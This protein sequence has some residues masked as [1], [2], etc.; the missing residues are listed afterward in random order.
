MLVYVHH[1]DNLVLGSRHLKPVYMFCFSRA[2]SVHR[3]WDKMEGCDVAVK[4]VKT[5]IVGDGGSMRCVAACLLLWVASQ[6][7]CDMY[8]RAKSNTWRLWCVL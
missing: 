8:R 5:T 6:D 2:R 1:S 3:A 4:I 7:G